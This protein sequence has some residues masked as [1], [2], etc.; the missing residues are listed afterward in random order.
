MLVSNWWLQW[1]LSKSITALRTTTGTSGPTLTTHSA[2]GLHTIATQCDRSS[3]HRG[4]SQSESIGCV[5]VWHGFDV[6]MLALRIW[7]D[8][9][10]GMCG[11]RYDERRRQGKEDFWWNRR[12][13]DSNFY[14]DGKTWMASAAVTTR[15]WRRSS[16]SRCWVRHSR[17]TQIDKRTVCEKRACSLRPT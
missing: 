8:C 12:F 14:S 5:C 3:M 15:G 4:Q 7:Q 11:A 2:C 9:D 10:I 16:S 13:L 1:R 17:V 6:T